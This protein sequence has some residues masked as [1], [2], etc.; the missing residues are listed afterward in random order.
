MDGILR[1][2]RAFVF[3][4]VD[5]SFDGVVSLGSVVPGG[6]EFEFAAVVQWFIKT[7]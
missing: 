7:V 1:Y 2:G 6:F 5:I 3:C 4:I